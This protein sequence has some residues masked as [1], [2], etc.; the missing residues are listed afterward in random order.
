MDLSIVINCS[1]DLHIFSTL[2]SIDEDVDI[3][4]S[5][6]PNQIIEADLT[7]LGF[8]YVLTPKGNQSLTTNTGIDYAKFEKI[9]LMDSDCKFSPGAIRLIANALDK[10]MVVNGKI[11]FENNGSFLSRMISECRDFD[12]TYDK[13]IY[14]PG[15]GV[16]KELVKYVCFWFNPIVRW[17]DDA[18]LS[19]RIYSAN[20]NITHLDNP[21]IYH[22]PISIMHNFRSSFRYGIADY[23]RV[24]FLSQKS[25]LSW[26]SYELTRYK[27][28]FKNKGL[29]VFLFML[30]NDLV[31]HS[32]YLSA[33]MRN[34]LK[35]HFFMES[36]NYEKKD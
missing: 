33:A 6:T 20:I 12:N 22:A 35:K 1:D 29:L 14:K 15:L 27:S 26:I 7:R 25:D 23:I 19:Y 10:Y 8:F 13:P 4:I 11:V 34:R 24:S 3:V 18:D 2:E 31:Y 32:G 30:L 17:T 36:N 16:R 28:L 5:M 9:I 21:C